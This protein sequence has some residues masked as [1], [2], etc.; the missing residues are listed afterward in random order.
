[1]AANLIFNAAILRLRNAARLLFKFHN[2]VQNSREHNMYEWLTEISESISVWFVILWLNPIPCLIFRTRIF[3][4]LWRKHL[5]FLTSVSY[6]RVL[7]F[8]SE[9]F[10]RTNLLRRKPVSDCRTLLHFS[11]MNFAMLVHC[12]FKM[13]WKYVANGSGNKL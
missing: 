11:S 10:S 2:N 7:T 5:P 8:R 6:Q 3:S 9:K 4:L 12:W 1:M 13:P